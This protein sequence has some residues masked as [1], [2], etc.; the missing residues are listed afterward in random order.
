MIPFFFRPGEAAPS[1]LEMIDREGD[2]FIFEDCRRHGDDLVT[3]EVG[4]RC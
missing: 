1:N 3:L 4:R 2:S